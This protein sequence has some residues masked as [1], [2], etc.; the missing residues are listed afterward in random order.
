VSVDRLELV[1]IIENQKAKLSPEG[2]ELW[3]ELEILEYMSPEEENILQRRQSQR[4][5]EDIA[6]RMSY[7]PPYDQGVIKV[8]SEL[9]AGLYESDK[10]SDAGA[11]GEARRRQ[12][13]HGAAR[14]KDI[15]EG[16][17]ADPDMTFEQAIARL[18]E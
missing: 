2:K 18:R 9:R 11:S 4:Q 1:E 16:R 17:Q 6:E 8:L 3:D 14:I 12:A 15:A 13:V 7:L 5:R 10:E